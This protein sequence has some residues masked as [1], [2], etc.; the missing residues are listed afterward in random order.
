M[1][2]FNSMKALYD[3][4]WSSRLN[5]TC[6]NSL[7]IPDV[8]GYRVLL[9]MTM[10]TKNNAMNCMTVQEQQTF[11][12]LI[13]VCLKTDFTVWSHPTR[14]YTY[15][16]SNTLIHVSAASCLRADLLADPV[17]ERAGGQ[18]ACWRDDRPEPPLPYWP[19]GG[20]CA[21]AAA[22]SSELYVPKDCRLEQLRL[23]LGGNWWEGVRYAGTAAC[24]VA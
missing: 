10:L 9:T 21:A 12:S 22:A 20:A 15:Q 23:G 19:P 17:C 2:D 18:P 16:S 3:V 7:T 6:C 1:F 8:A 13:D 4:N 11:K 24:S 14:S 5:P